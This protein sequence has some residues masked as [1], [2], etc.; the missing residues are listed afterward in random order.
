MNIGLLHVGIEGVVAEGHVVDAGREA[1]GDQRRHLVEPNVH[2]PIVDRRAILGARLPQARLGILRAV[3]DLEQEVLGRIADFP[4][5]DDG[6]QRTLFLKRGGSQ[7]LIR[8]VEDEGTWLRAR[9][10]S[11]W[12]ESMLTR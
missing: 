3:G 2:Q 11:D 5:C 4:R 8:I 9:T 10:A 1:G 7:E 6:P 12:C